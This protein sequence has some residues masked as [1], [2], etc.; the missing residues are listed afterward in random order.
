MTTFFI[1]RAPDELHGR[2]ESDSG[3]CFVRYEMITAAAKAADVIKKGDR[4]ASVD[5]TSGSLKKLCE[6]LKAAPEKAKITVV[7][8]EPL[9]GRGITASG[10]MGTCSLACTK[11]M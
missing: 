8:G 2:P 1:V 3:T 5:G 4:I 7:R 11:L 6:A 9:P 10:V